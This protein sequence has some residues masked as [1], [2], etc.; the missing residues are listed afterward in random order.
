M[1]LNF[2][3]LLRRFKVPVSIT[4]WLT[5]MEALDR[6]YAL[7]SLNVFYYL[8]RAI[9]V[10]SETYYDQFDQAFYAAFGKIKTDEE[11]TD[12]VLEWLKD[13][14]NRLALDPE[15]LEKLKRYDLETLRAMFE[16]RLREQDERHDG[17]GR[18]IGTGGTSPFGHGGAHPAGVRVGGPGGGG[19][20]V[21]IAQERRFR[22]YRTDLTLDIRQIK[23]ALK[24]LRHF[25]REGPEDELDL[26]ETID[27][28]CKNAGEIELVFGRA[29]RNTVKVCLMM[30]SGGS[31]A[32]FSELVNRLFSAA[33]QMSHFKDLKYY[34]FH[35]C[36]YQE[37]FE[38]IYN[39]KAVP[40][41]SV[42]SNLDADYKL[43]MVGDAHMA[44][45]ELFSKGGAIDY[46]YHNE[47]PGIEWLQRLADHFRY[48][49]WLNPINR[50]QIWVHPTIKAIGRVFPM[51]ELTLDGID[52][53]VKALMVRR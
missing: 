16:E 7:S 13:P 14:I 48:A 27:K 10:K 9:L 22:N 1:F 29:R 26:K 6:G 4:E 30:D 34:Y 39:S 2:F 12:E 37:L 24:R 18:W 3:Y 43:I 44:P 25:K 19:S 17:G 51:F 33:H 20:A 45:S 31:M 8:A 5:L 35:N 11:I 32:P 21:Q 47:I 28:T 49:V 53:A 23:V 50:P 41:G 40:T 42:M 15:E 36:V 52:Q 38:D 46:W